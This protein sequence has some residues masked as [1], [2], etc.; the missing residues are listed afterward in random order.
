MVPA[1]APTLL[2]ALDDPDPR[3]RLA[4]LGAIRNMQPPP[5]DALTAIAGRL[6]DADAEVRMQAADT[7][8][9]F[10]A[11]AVASLLPAFDDREPRVRASVASAFRAIGQPARN[12]APA[13]RAHL[14]DAAPSVRLNAA[15]ALAAVGADDPASVAALA[16]ALDDAEHTVRWGAAQALGRLGPAA[17]AARPALEHARNDTH[18]LVRTAAEDALMHLGAAPR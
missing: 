4:I 6:A 14:T 15:A 3:I 1:A 9:H 17:G 2:A 12:A 16:T 18:P 13:L 5:A 7:L 8:G 11:A 10:G